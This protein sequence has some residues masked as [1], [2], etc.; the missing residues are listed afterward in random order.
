MAKVTPLKASQ[1]GKNLG[2]FKAKSFNLFEPDELEAY[3]ELRTKA[4]DLSNGI[5]IETIREYSRKT[6]KTEGYG[7][8]QVTTT[9]EE[10]ILVVQ[11][12]ERPVARKKGDSDDE[13]AE[14]RSVIAPG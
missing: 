9:T 8:T 2:E 7:E 14:D 3:S 4:A 12:W 13:I 5:R 10:I 11:Y 6:T 1:P